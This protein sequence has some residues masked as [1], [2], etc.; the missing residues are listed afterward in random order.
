MAPADSILGINEAFKVCKSSN[1]VN[2]CVGAYRDENGK[3]WVLPSVREAEL[4]M[5]QDPT[6]NKEYASISGDS[7]FVDLALKFAYGWDADL[8]RVAG[9]QS[10][11]G[12]GACRIGGQFLSNFLPKGTKIYVPVPTWGNHHSI[13]KECGLSVSTY[14]YYDRSTNALDFHGMMEDFQNAPDGSILL[15]HACAHNPTGCDPT[16][17][18]WK[19]I[20]DLCK[21]KSHH[22]FFDSAYQGFASGD[23]E[24]D[25]AAL[26]LFVNEG[27]NI[28]LAQSFAK[29]FGL[30]GE[31]CGTLSV[32]TNSADDKERVMSQLKIIIRPMYSSPPIHGANIVKSVLSDPGLRDQYYGE[33]AKMAKRI[34]EMRILLVQ[35]LKEAGSEHNWSHVL[36]QIGMFAFTGKYI[37]KLY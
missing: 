13:F 26:R 17:E 22:V 2:I 7:T 9:V 28:L 34:G 19:S 12:T 20:S 27:H 25:A 3:P 1:K 31:R 10:L 18:Q 8:S 5:L 16:I 24:G 35:R 15:L 37:I 30:Y 4:R 6:V 14:R 11:S 23:A 29:N 33:C 21:Q 36:S 32:V